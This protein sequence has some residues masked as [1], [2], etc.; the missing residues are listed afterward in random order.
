L[1]LG[2]ACAAVVAVVF[3]MEVRSLRASFYHAQSVELA[4]TDPVSALAVAERAIELNPDNPYYNG[5]AADM[6]AQ[7][8]QFDKAI[9]LYRKAI[10]NDAYRASYHWRL[11]RV[12]A[13]AGGKESEAVEQF[14]IAVHLNPTKKLYQEDLRAAEESIRH[15]TAPLLESVPAEKVQ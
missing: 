11:A 14:K 4:L 13:V 6:A 12:L 9:T 3:W 1:A 8:S 15:R 2:T 5:T 10:A 7:L